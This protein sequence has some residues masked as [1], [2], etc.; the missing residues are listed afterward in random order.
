MR[1]PAVRGS[2]HEPVLP[3]ERAALSGQWVIV[4]IAPNGVVHAFGDE[5]GPYT[6][7]ARAYRRRRHMLAVDKQLYPSSTEPVTMK[8]CKII[9]DDEALR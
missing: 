7:R 3:G 2:L 6:D 4:T 9:T 8:V 5:D 1:G